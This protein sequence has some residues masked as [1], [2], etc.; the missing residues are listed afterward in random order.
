MPSPAA[1]ENAAQRREKILLAVHVS[2]LDRGYPPTLRE[3]A[4][5]LGVS[6]RQIAKDVKR[7]E[8]DNLLTHNKSI[9]RSLRIL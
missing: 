9:P 7:L 1:L 8:R 2:V 5:D 4:D 6:R 3:L